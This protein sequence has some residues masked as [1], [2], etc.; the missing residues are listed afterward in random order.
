MTGRFLQALFKLTLLTLLPSAND[1]SAAIIKGMIL[2][3]GEPG[4]RW[5]TVTSD[6]YQQPTKICPGGRNIEL[7]Q[8]PGSIVEITGSERKAY[9]KTPECFFADSYNILEIASGRPA[10]IGV[11]TK[12]D[13][14]TYAVVNDSG[15]KWVLQKIPPGMRD[16]IK[17]KVVCDL[18]ATIAEN[19]QT[20]WLV[21]RA[22]ALP[23]P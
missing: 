15:K 18:V 6:S 11:L 4:Q 8:L 7:V 3:A 19:G 9:G 2:S 17:L 1:V 22:F 20:K 16:L 23:T 13:N 21:A 10:I 12:I 14:D 5:T